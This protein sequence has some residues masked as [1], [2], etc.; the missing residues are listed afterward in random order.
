[1]QLHPLRYTI[2][3]LDEC[4]YVE[5]YYFTLEGCTEAVKLDW[6]VAQDTFTFA[7]ANETLLLKP[8][9]SHKPSSK[10]ILD[11]DLT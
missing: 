3:K 4:D 1:M 7:K 10:V 8:I 5:L 6:T 2:H 11:E 9:V